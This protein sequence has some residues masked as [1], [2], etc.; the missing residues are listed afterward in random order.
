MIQE[1]TSEK[2]SINQIPRTHKY[3][4][5][6]GKGFK[7]FDNGA[8]KYLKGT[9]F[10]QN[11]GIFNFRF[12]PYNVS[13]VENRCSLDNKGEY[14]SSTISNVLN[15]IKEREVQIEVIQRSYD[16]LQD[17][18]FCLITVHYDK[19]KKSG[20]TNKGWQWHKPLKEYIPLVNE[21]FD[22][23]EIK[24][25]IIIASKG[26]FIKSQKKLLTN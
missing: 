5:T 16:M 7:N 1:F 21:V 11:N 20:P 24:N 15:T 8:G 23:V 4:A 3:L 19:N 9:T 13:D 18:G 22:T 14:T 2:T 12:D 26:S 17:G 6:L 25:N 10:L